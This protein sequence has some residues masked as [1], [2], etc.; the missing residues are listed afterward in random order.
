MLKFHIPS[1]W[2]GKLSITILFK[3]SGGSFVKVDSLILKFI[4]KSKV[5]VTVKTILKKNKVGKFTFH[6]FKTY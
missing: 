2:I 5:S 4:W 6:N 1:S 3:T